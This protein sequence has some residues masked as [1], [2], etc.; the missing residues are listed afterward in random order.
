MTALPRRRLASLVLALAPLCWTLDAVAETRPERLSL[1]GVDL[2][3]TGVEP[4]R[5]AA[6]AAGAASQGRKGAMERFNVTALK[7]PAIKSLTVTYAGDRVMAAQYDIDYPHEELRKMLQSKYGRPVVTDSRGSGAS[8]FTAEYASDGTYS[9]QF[10]GGMQLV[11]KQPFMGPTTLT[12]VNAELLKAVE[13]ST[14][15]RADKEAQDK[16]KEK[17]SMF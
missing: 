7:L 12:Y 15:G 2:A 13:N 3:A 11:F 8:D 6:R 14:K 17:S 10:P 16:A 9:W 5:A 1:F 4:F